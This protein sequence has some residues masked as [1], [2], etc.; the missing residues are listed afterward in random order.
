MKTGMKNRVWAVVFGVLTMFLVALLLSAVAAALI[1]GEVLPVGAQKPICWVIGAVAAFLGAVICAGR[2]GQ[3]RL[4]LCLVAAA[5]YLLLAFVLRGL[6]FEEVGSQP[7]LVP[8]LTVLGSVLG[9]LITS[10]KKKRRY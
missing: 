3:Q 8:V 1:S 7:W 4:P 10:G 2:A 9:A 6:L 5:V